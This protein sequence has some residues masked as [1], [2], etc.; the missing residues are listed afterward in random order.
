MPG[1]QVQPA[2]ESE[3]EELEDLPEVNID[4]IEDPVN[5]YISSLPF[6]RTSAE[7]FINVVDKATVADIPEQANCLRAVDFDRLSLLLK[8]PAWKYGY[9]YQFV[10]TIFER[11]IE[12]DDFSSPFNLKVLGLLWC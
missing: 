9:N 4:A 12:M 2:V 1:Q 6:A 7:V 3:V 10:G 5:K 8:S 11:F